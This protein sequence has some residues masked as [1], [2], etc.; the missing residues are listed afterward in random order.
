MS[1]PI[2]V[3]ADAVEIQVLVVPRASRSRVIGMHGDRIK[4]QLAAP[5]VD[6]A[7]NEELATL[8]ADVLDVPRR[9][10]AVVRGQTARRKTVRIEA[11]D[12]DA[13]RRRLEPCS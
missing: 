6:G 12:A 1:D 3:V 5:P 4:I 11:A 7:A 2:R 8:L 10:I 13:I 9:S